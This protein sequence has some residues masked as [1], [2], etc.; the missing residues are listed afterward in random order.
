WFDSLEAR[1]AAGASAE[2]KRW[3]ADGATIIG[4]IRMYVTQEHFVVPVPA[5]HRPKFKTLSVIK[6]RGEFS[7]KDFRHEWIDVH[8]PMAR[9]VPGLREF[10]LSELVEEQSR[11]DIPPFALDGPPDGF[12]ESW[13][14]SQAARANMMASVEGKSWFAHGATFIGHIRSIL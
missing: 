7:A 14:D 8:G 2:G 3:H 1:A 10:T 13:W 6:R 11:A 9:G 4:A 5:A 12:A